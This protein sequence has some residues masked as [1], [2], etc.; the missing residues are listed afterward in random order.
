MYHFAIVTINTCFVL[1]KLHSPDEPH[2][3]VKPVVNYPS[4][5]NSNNIQNYKNI[6]D[7]CIL[8]LHSIKHNKF[9]GPWLLYSLTYLLTLSN[10]E[11]RVVYRS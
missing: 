6:C 10:Y 4:A 1:V 5:K 9:N 2:N 8:S 11:L 3:T 7:S